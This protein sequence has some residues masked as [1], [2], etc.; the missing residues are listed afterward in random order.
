MPLI[1][2]VNFYLA[3]G[4]DLSVQGSDVRVDIFKYNFFLYFLNIIIFLKILLYRL[5]FDIFFV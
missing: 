5:S 3:E 4:G 1:F 2:F